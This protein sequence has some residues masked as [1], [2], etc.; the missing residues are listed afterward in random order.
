VG[1]IGAQDRWKPPGDWPN[2]PT[3][4]PRSYSS[5]VDDR[6]DEEAVEFA[7]HRARV[8]VDEWYRAVEMQHDRALGPTVGAPGVDVSEEVYREEWYRRQ[9]DV[10]FYVFALDLFWQAVSIVR[11]RVLDGEAALAPAS[12]PSRTLSPLGELYGMRSRTSTNATLARGGVRLQTTRLGW[13]YF[14]GELC[15]RRLQSF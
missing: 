2:R 7:A 13:S 10:V 14:W 1:G 3:T 4:G 11:K 15:F 5:V 8:R 12:P 6:D 9:R